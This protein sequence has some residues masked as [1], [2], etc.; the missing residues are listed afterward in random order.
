MTLGSAGLAARATWY[1]AAVI[2]PLELSHLVGLF[3]DPSDG[4][5]GKSQELTLHLLKHSSAPLSRAQFIPGHI[6]T[7]GLVLSPD[8]SA[9]LLIHHRRLERWLLPGGHVEPEDQTIFD[10]ARR[11]VVEETGAQLVASTGAPLVGLDVHAIPPGKGEPLHYHHDL[12]FLFR[13]ESSRLN[14]GIEVREARWFP[15]ASLAQGLPELPQNIQL[16]IVRANTSLE[17]L[18]H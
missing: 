1:S 11:E 6:T 5:A 8:L 15:V 4:A 12:V 7:T 3:S 10:A 13:A 17:H 9:V 18:K 14:Q 16:S 2:D